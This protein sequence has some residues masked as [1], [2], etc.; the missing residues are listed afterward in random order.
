MVT[1]KKGALVKIDDMSLTHKLIVEVLGGR[2]KKAI[3]DYTRE[4]WLLTGTSKK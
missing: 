4:T 2:N 3:N 1:I